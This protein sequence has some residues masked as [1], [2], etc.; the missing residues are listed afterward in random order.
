MYHTC[1]KKSTCRNSFVYYKT[2][3]S[4]TVQTLDGSSGEQNVSPAFMSIGQVWARIEPDL[5]ITHLGVDRG[6]ALFGQPLVGQFGIAAKMTL[7]YGPIS[8]PVDL[9]HVLPAIFL[10]GP[11]LAIATYI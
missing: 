4:K 10:D 5:T 7:D 11:G 6:Q 3:E 1:D 2:P 8:S 9:G